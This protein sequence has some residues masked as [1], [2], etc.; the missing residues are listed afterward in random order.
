MNTNENQ[1]ENKTTPAENIPEISSQTEKIIAE[2][3]ASHPQ[4]KRLVFCNRL[5][6]ERGCGR[7]NRKGLERGNRKGDFYGC[8]EDFD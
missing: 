4:K 6:D 5:L 7:L 3:L 8:G 1:N 2:L